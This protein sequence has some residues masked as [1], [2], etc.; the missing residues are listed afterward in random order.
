MPTIVAKV[1]KNSRNAPKVA[2]PL[3][4]R[5]GDQMLHK[6]ALVDSELSVVICDD[7]YIHELNLEHR[8]K[9]KPTDVLS[10]PQAEFRAAEKPRRGH[11]LDL[12]GD[13]VISLTTAQR[14]ADS[15]HRSLESEVKFLLA[16]GILHLVGHD[17]MTVDDKRIMTNRTRQLVR[18]ASRDD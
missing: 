2:L 16:H 17:H 7:T 3:V 6:L 13:V 9:D 11:S 14:Q 12:L 15:R 10:F 4:R 8:G 18:A 1:G 5:W